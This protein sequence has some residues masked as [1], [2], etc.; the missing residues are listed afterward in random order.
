MREGS[1]QM[2]QRLS[3]VTPLVIHNLHDQ[4][5]ESG[6]TQ[7]PVPSRNLSPIQNLERDGHLLLFERD[8][9]FGV[10]KRRDKISLVGQRLGG[11][12]SGNS[13]SCG[14][15]KS[16]TPTRG[17]R[18]L[19]PSRNSG[20]P[21]KGHTPFNTPSVGPFPWSGRSNATILVFGNPN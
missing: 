19:V 15:C 7:H 18:P 1:R 2:V 3:G 20:H 21:M 5:G 8:R 10:S 13:K 14:S 4:L 6:P 17:P 9:E 16:L 11:G 12:G